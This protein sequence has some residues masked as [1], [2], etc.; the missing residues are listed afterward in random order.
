MVF[1]P[2]KTLTAV[3]AH[4][5][6]FPDPNWRGR[7]HCPDV[8]ASLGELFPYTITYLL[9]EL[10][11]PIVTPFVLYFSLRPRAAAVVDFFKNF[12][13]EVQGVGDVCSFAQMDVRRHGDTEWQGLENNKAQE[14]QQ[15][16]QPARTTKYTRAECGKTEMSLVHF[17]LVNPG[18]KPPQTE[19]GDFI[20]ALKEQV[21]R[22]A[23]ALPT[24]TEETAPGNVLYSS[25]Q[26]SADSGKGEI[27][28]GEAEVEAASALYSSMAGNFLNEARQ[29]M[30]SSSQNAAARSEVTSPQSDY[31]NSRISV[32]SRNN[33]PAGDNASMLASHMVAGGGVGANSSFFSSRMML[34]AA[35][36][37][38]NLRQD[39]RRLGLEY[40]AADMSLSALYLHELHQ[41]SVH[42]SSSRHYESASRYDFQQSRLAHRAGLERR[43]SLNELDE[44][45]NLPL[46]DA[47]PPSSPQNTASK[48]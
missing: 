16:Q 18:W 12:T 3:L 17:S 34:G 8:M 5:H 14:Q 20:S 36:P 32:Y 48:R 10:L 40:T 6:Y 31:V 9:Q 42:S 37:A 1:C 47:P 15:Q 30:R 22:E 44:E 24:L 45:E 38:P 11:S 19:S 25:L 29:R 35:P 33:A 27:G 26:A 4:T 7:A 43:A 39:L 28:G 21:G 2:E 13:V 41:R 46:L 23:E